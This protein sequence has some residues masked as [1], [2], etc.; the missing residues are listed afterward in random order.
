MKKN[1]YWAVQKKKIAGWSSIT[2]EKTGVNWVFKDETSTC[3]HAFPSQSLRNMGRF[4][5][6]SK[7][8]HTLINTLTEDGETYEEVKKIKRKYIENKKKCRNIL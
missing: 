1:K 4:I 6:R 7:E 5:H 3:S 8:Q 2:G